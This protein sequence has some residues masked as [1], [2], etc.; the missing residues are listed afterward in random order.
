MIIIIYIFF[1]VNIYGKELNNRPI[2]GIL[3]QPSPNYLSKYGDTYLTASYVKWIESSGGRV[4]PI[5][6][7][8]SKDHLKELFFSING[9]IFTG[10]DLS[11]LKNTTYYQ[12][13][14]FFYNLA[15]EANK[16]GD[17]FPSK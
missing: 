16:N 9:I 7:K 15:I 14:L 4:I 5:P 11:L 2:I 3:D 12:T 13:S 1:I 17:Y 8:A 6:H 10:G